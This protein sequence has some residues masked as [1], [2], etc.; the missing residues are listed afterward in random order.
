MR[1]TR[2]NSFKLFELR[3]DRNW[4]S[5]LN[6]EGSREG[7]EFADV[8]TKHLRRSLSLGARGLDFEKDRG[9]IEE[10]MKQQGGLRDGREIDN[11]TAGM[12]QLSA[13]VILS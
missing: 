3:R 6:Q 5:G 2:S 9:K 7:R 11:G 12:F 8:N 10:V 13:W 4:K 1:G